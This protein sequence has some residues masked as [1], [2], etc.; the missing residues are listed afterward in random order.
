[1]PEF[2]VVEFGVLGPVRAASGETNATLPARERILLA[3]LLLRAGRVVAT[4]ALIEAIWDGEPPATARNS[5]QGSVKHLRKLL[6]PAAGG[7]IVTRSPGYLIDVRP[8]ELDLDRFTRLTGMASDSAK[9]D[10]WE[11]ASALLS[12]ALALW[13]GQPLSDVPSAVLQQTEVPRLDELRMRAVE[14][15]VEAELRLGRC[16]EL[17]PELRRLTSLEPLREGLHRQLMRALYRC[18]RQAEALEVFRSAD[19]WL[20]DELGIGAGP[21]LRLLHQQILAADPPPPTDDSEPP[22]DLVPIP[23]ADVPSPG[24]AALMGAQA[25]VAPS[26]PSAGE[27]GGTAATAATAGAWRLPVPRQLPAATERFVGRAVELQTLTTLLGSTVVT[28]PVAAISGPPG[29]GKTTL[30][31]RWAHLAAGDFPDGQLYV[32]LRGFD[33]SGEP[34]PATAAIRDFLDALHVPMER[35]PEGL[36]AQAALYRSLLA[37]RRVLVVLDNARDAAQVRP[38]LPGMA[39]C[40]TVVTSRSRLPGLMAAEGARP[41]ILKPLSRG[42]AAELLAR[43]IGVERVT[44]DE[45]AADEVIECCVRLPL[46]ISVAAARAAI[47][48]DVPLAELAAELRDAKTRL[49]FLDTRDVASSMR[50]VYSWS[51]RQLSP[52]A[53]RMFR[54]LGLHPGPD[55]SLPAAASMACLALPEARSVLEELVLSSLLTED[56]PGRYWLHDLLRVYAAEEALALEDAAER[57]C[58]MHRLLDHYLISAYRAALLLDPHRETLDLPAARHGVIPER[59]ADHDEALAWCES[60]YAVLMGAITAADNHQFDRHAWQLYWCLRS[61]FTVRVRPHQWRSAAIIALS[62]AG[63]A[64][65]GFGQAQARHG[66]GSAYTAMGRYD[67]ARPHYAAAL[68]LYEA[69]GDHLGQA[70]VLLDL[71]LSYEFRERHHDVFGATS[72]RPHRERDAHM[73]AALAHAR[74]ALELFREAAH[75][76]GEA[77]ACGAVGRSLALHGSAQEAVGYCERAVQMN[78]DLGNADAEAIALISLGYALHKAGRYA[79]AATACQCALDLAQRGRSPRLAAIALTHLA[80]SHRSAENIPAARAAWAQ[81]LVILDDLQLPDADQVRARLAAYARSD[82]S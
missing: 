28:A 5:V 30:A 41:L 24:Q 17:I 38:L 80:E 23:A 76:P 40:L 21:E 69:L 44:D 15:R 13:R 31:L 2:G 77:T 51:C 55:V 48:P 32:N 61:Y 79:D 62:A 14:S 35:I 4:S 67:D 43:G 6:H 73:H 71:G 54:L 46:A 29:V 81:A 63:R 7:R 72:A 1:V 16:G 27:E 66:L 26:A 18:G 50:T 37:G 42:E 64:S 45:D 59:I 65:D 22:V 52:P 11:R 34:L 10:D 19:R 57:R 25:G 49:D 74:R 68:G 78:H 60:E 9:A 8:G 3:T 39:G 33:A 56:R 36:P 53:A 20:R 75:R 70:R 12:D 47:R 82:P 58:A